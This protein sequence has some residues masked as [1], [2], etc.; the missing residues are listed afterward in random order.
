MPVNRL[1]FS[2][3]SKIHIRQSLSNSD[4][5]LEQENSS[6][7]TARPFVSI[8][9]ASYNERSVI[10]RLMSSCSGLT[11]DKNKFEVIVVDDSID[12]TLEELEKWQS[13]MPN[14]K[15]LHR[16]NRDGWKG[17]ALNFAIHKLNKKSEYTLIVDA[18]HMLEMDTLQKFVKCFNISKNKLTVVQ[19]FPIP[20][21]YSQENWVTRGVYFRL[22]KRNLIEFVA[23]DDMGLPLQITGSLFMIRSYVLRKIKFSHDLTEDWELTLDLHLKYHT[24]NYKK[25]LF[26]P[27][28]IAHCEAPVKLYTYFKQRLRV[29]EGHT[30]GFKMQFSNILKSSLPV[31]K[32]IE[33]IFTGTQYAKFLLILA[34]IVADSLRLISDDILPI[35]SSLFFVSALAIQAFTLCL[36]V[37]NNIVSTHLLG[38]HFNY[39]DVLYL[40]AITAC[41]F[42]AFVIGSTRGIIRKNGVFHKTE[43]MNQ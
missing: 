14:L 27:M 13:V 43:R 15:I 34:L 2:T 30:R 29:S 38:D 17:G 19:G 35:E 41:T 12:G 1:L 11:Y 16:S 42:P 10:N 7:H 36:Y 33:L 28:A 5:N 24:I 22:V 23:K 32:K 4:M 6:S 31:M 9:V 39:K 21:I 18:D 8:L 3:L 26:Y 37:A 25:I 20:S 40:V